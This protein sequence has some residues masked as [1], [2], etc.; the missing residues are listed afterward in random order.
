L[1]HLEQLLARKPKQLSGGQRQR[2]A[3]GRAIV[4]EPKLFLFDEP[5]SNLDAKLRVRMRVELLNLHYETRNTA[6][7]VTHDQVE[8]MTMADRIVI[9]NE[10]RIEQVGSP[11]ELY[12]KPR[13]QFVAGF[14]GSPQ[15]N[16]LPLTVESQ[17]PA[18]LRCRSSTFGT[19]SLPLQVDRPLES[20]T[21]TLGVRPEHVHLGA[22]PGT[23]TL[24]GVV[25]IIENLGSE[26]FVHVEL[27]ENTMLVAKSKPGAV[28]DRNHRAQ[29]GLE[30]EHLYLFGEDHDSIPVTPA[31]VAAGASKSSKG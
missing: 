21:V 24:P 11:L 30:V 3:I 8:A 5:L 29:V 15:M 1:L 16:M 25:N 4:K 20:K 27:G 31:P 14:I 7:Y 13:N 17:K 26:T 10:G 18:L 28:P 9:L 2:V 19:I 6:V 12:E 23:V 22:V